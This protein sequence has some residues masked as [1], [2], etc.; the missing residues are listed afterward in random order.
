MSLHLLG[1]VGFAAAADNPY[2]IMAGFAAITDYFCCCGRLQL[3]D[4]R[5]RRSPGLH[6]L[7]SSLASITLPPVSSSSLGYNFKSAM[8]NTAIYAKIQSGML[9][10]IR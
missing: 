2:F 5:H 9:Q 1:V 7:I 6:H 3:R 8:K 10:S 4:S